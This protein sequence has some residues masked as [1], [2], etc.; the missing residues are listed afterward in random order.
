MIRGT[1]LDWFRIQKS[2]LDVCEYQ[3]GT[4]VVAKHISNMIPHCF[5]AGEVKYFKIIVDEA[6]E[7]NALRHQ[8]LE[9]RLQF[10]D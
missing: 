6:D 8:S 5:A 7:M 1:V 9:T 10:A 3:F 2:K 4:N